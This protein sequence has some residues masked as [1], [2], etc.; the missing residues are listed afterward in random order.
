MLIYGAIYFNR[1]TGN[2]DHM[3]NQPGQGANVVIAGTDFCFLDL[4]CD[5]LLEEKDTR[6]RMCNV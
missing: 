2:I 3:R 5:Y 4:L 6:G 1:V